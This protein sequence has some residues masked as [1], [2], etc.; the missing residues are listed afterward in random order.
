LA[1]GIAAREDPK[2]AS[3]LVSR[4]FVRKSISKR[5]SGAYQERSPLGVLI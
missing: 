2:I 1:C 5:R 4:A 3:N